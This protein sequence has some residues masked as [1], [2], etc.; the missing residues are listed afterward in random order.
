MLPRAPALAERVTPGR[1]VLHADVCLALQTPLNQ[2]QQ[3]HPQTRVLPRLC[4]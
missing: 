2:T 3:L 1:P 4:R